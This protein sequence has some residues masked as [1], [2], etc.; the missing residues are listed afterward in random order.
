V[1][2]AAVGPSYGARTLMCP[3]ENI[4]VKQRRA[5]DTRAKRLTDAPLGML[6]AQNPTELAP[7]RGPVPSRCLA[8][9]VG[10]ELAGELM[11]DTAAGERNRT[12]G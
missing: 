5:N 12:R 1:A 3:C 11:D 7:G 2:F 10:D 9:D 4:L 6:H 8:F